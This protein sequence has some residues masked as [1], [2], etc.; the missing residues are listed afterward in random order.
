MDGFMKIALLLVVLGVVALVLSLSARRRLARE[1]A[2][3]ALA[4]ERARRQGRIPVV[5]NNLKGVTAS[6]TA[7]PYRPARAGKPDE[8]AA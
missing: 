4:R 3:A 6:Q 7:E 2:A 5:S 8:R 1:Q